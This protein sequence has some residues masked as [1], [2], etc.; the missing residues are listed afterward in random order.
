MITCLAVCAAMRPNS[1]VSIF[2]PIWSSGSHSGSWR[3]AASRPTSA[4]FCGVPSTTVLN[5]K[6]STSP[7]SRLNLPSMSRS[8]PSLR[9]AAETMAFSRVSMMMSGSIP[10]SFPT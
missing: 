7:V 3:R 1:A 10:L 5:S 8:A 4:S 2:R 9:L 6:S